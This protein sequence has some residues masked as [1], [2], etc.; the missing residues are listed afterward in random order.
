ME[1]KSC[2]KT[3]AET[4]NFS[5]VRGFILES[6]NSRKFN[7]C[8]WHGFLCHFWPTEGIGDALP[9]FKSDTS[10]MS[11]M[12]ML[13]EVLCEQLCHPI[14][15]RVFKGHTTGV[16]RT[17]TQPTK[18]YWQSRD[19]HWAMRCQTHV[20]PVWTCSCLR[21][22]N[23]LDGCKQEP[24][25][26]HHKKHSGNIWKLLESHESYLKVLKVT[27]KFWKSWNFLESLESYLKVRN[28]WSCLLEWLPLS[29]RIWKQA[30]YLCDSFFELI[31]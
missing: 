7:V 17:L 22:N 2:R 14:N 29:G 20:N 12:C 5:K 31:N 23:H 27:W 11:K 28:I 18:R 16:L 19:L 13:A 15:P 26:V 10:H 8:L 1:N 3:L 24:K 25:K 9:S 4:S 6:L 21:I 30:G